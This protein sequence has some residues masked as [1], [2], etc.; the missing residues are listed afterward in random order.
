MNL[1]PPLSLYVHIPW[2]VKKCLYCDFNSH[3]LRSDVSAEDYVDALINDIEAYR[4]QIQ[5]RV[6]QTIFFGGGKP[7]VF[8]PILIGKLINYVRE[9]FVLSI[10]A[11]VTLEDNTGA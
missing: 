7:S 10:D 2:C 9:N 8:E 6:I 1:L 3:P 11:E 5:D 4:W